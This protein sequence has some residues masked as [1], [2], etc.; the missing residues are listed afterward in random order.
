MKKRNIILL[1]L[2]V[3][4]TTVVSLLY[5]G[6]SQ[7][8]KRAENSSVI[9]DPLTITCGI[10]TAPPAL[11]LLRMIET[12]ALGENV[13]FEY[14]LWTSPEQ[15]VSMLQGKEGDMF[16][17]PLTLAAKLY[18]KG[19]G[20]ALTNVNTWGVT[21]FTTIDPDFKD[22]TDLK[23]KTI[24]IPLRSS[25]PDCLTQV[26]LQNA[27]VDL[28]KDIEII[29]STQAEIANLMAAGKIEYATQ[30]EPQCTMSMMKNPEIR[31]VFSF[32]ECWQELKQN[33]TDQPNAGWGVRTSF[34]EAHPELMAQFEAEYKKAVEWVVTN[35]AEAAQL[36]HEKL[37]MSAAV[38]E[39]G[40]PRM[41]IRYQTAQ[42]AKDDCIALF[43]LLYSFDPKTIGGKIPDGG[44]YYDGQD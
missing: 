21:Y 42:E 24:Y 2:V 18:N 22:W 33:D 34:I 25:P 43:T 29:Y 19:I 12:Q 41:G 6:G 40:I 7:E 11:P 3:L 9:S 27:G 28:K 4:T 31:S 44:L 26:F 32:T 13:H 37:H 8:K 14:T 38:F 35:P 1:Y 10:P 36:A 15:L 5:A 16:A 20:L 30:I 39:K 17:F 23:G